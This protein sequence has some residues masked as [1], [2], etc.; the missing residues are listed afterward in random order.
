M[1]PDYTEDLLIEQPA[2]ELLRSLGW[3]E[4]KNLFHET[5]G[6]GGTEKRRSRREVILTHRLRK[7]LVRLNSLLPSEAIDLAVE[8]LTR[9]RSALIPV[10]A[11]EEYYRLLK[12]GVKVAVKDE[13]G[14]TN[15]ETVRVIDWNNAGNNDFFLASQFWVEGSLYTRRADLV[16]F[17]NGLPLLFIELK[18]SHRKLYNAYKDNL[19]DYK[20]AIPQLFVPNAVVILSNG[21][22][23]RLGSIT[24]GW[25]HFFDWKRISDEGEKGAVSL[26]IVL[27]GVCEPARFLDIVENFTVFEAV[28]GGTAKKISKNHQYLGVNRALESVIEAKENKGRLGVF[29]HTQGSGKS[30]SMVFFTQKILRKLAGNWTFLIVTDRDDLDTQIYK[31]FVATGA[32]TEEE[33]QA[34]SGE[35]LK[36]L[37]K[38]DHRYVFTLIQKFRAER[39]SLYPTLSERDDVIVI[40]DE[41]HRSQYDT[42]AMNMRNA[43]PNASFIGFTGT[44]LIRGEEEKTREVFGDY[45]SVYN[46]RRSIE[47]RAT[48]PLYYENRIP[49]LQ[50]KNEDL[51]RELERLLEDAELDEA[52]ERK[53]ERE[54]SRQ[55]HLITREER[56]DTIA[57]DV[58]EHFIGRGYQGKAM[59]IAVDKVT[60][61]KMYDK[62]K[63]YWQ[64]K[65]EE[66]TRQLAEE[67]LENRAELEAQLANLKSTDM[68]V[69]VSQSQNEIEDM[70][71]KGVEIE[72]HRR[73]I[74]SED[75]EEMF[76]D[77]AN[78]FRLAF[79]CAMWITGFDVPTCSTIYLDKP[80]R[81]HTLMQTIARAN[82]VA[83][84]K[85]AGLIV[86]YVGM[87]RDLQKALAIY[88]TEQG[89]GGQGALVDEPIKDKKALVGELQTI[90]SEL[91]EFCA[92]LGFRLEDIQTAEGFDKIRLLD[93]AVEILIARLEDKKHFL[94]ESQ[95]VNNLFRAIL[96]DTAASEIAP[97][98]TLIYVLRQKIQ[99]LNPSADIS[100]IMAGVEGILDESIAVE[101]YRIDA[102]V[103]AE[104]DVQ[105]LVDL[106]QIDFE[107]LKE[108][109]RV[110]S[111][112]HTELEKLKNQIEARLA[113]MLELNRTR[114]NFL[115]RF[116]KMIDEYN[117]GSRNLE[118]F[119]QELIDFA[120][121]L[122]EED[123]R[124]IAEGLTEEEL[125]IFDILTKPEPK[126]TKA[127]EIEVKRVAK[128][129]LEK[130]KG[131]KL[132]LD[133]RKRQQTRAEVLVTIEE[134][135]DLLP[136]VYTKPIYDK[137]CELA[138]EHFYV[139]YPSAGKSVYQEQ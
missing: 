127:E 109:F 24:A 38:E 92:R 93:D 50:L 14:A 75:L 88:A 28:R 40:T 32:V 84:G 106:S 134:I 63:K 112:K 60:A 70:R 12:D 27:R 34:T 100:D 59:F 119:F 116:Q 9:D 99:A 4:Y 135:L 132:V 57:R 11:N 37:L 3:S 101:G 77:P 79:V 120:Q 90:I 86:D 78:P 129:L 65:T 13:D 125:A 49:Q 111:R 113:R 110:T 42:L 29:W 102:P 25:E 138:Y 52:Q 139:Q 48:V 67:T 108:K 98:A 44:P 82:R 22:E 128:T 122:N 105:G 72:P 45:V 130:I 7:A 95:I 54:F 133:W 36:Q 87:F 96:P 83:E 58:V 107:A 41:A 64:I 35:N 85:V 5:F 26:E 97:N 126:L 137:K 30:L 6:D 23:T 66:I 18:T 53:L 89:D 124:K 46:F 39:G 81:N 80:M 17:I 51:D 62:V 56:L 91:K 10:N 20:T 16:G 21:T 104:G 19:R 74:V 76:K 2:I 31:T 121:N 43:L 94:V 117:A 1:T 33:A 115:E 136:P 8:E 103:R 15:Y 114:V 55:Y 131:E 69:I 68:A 123:Q 118:D 71:A 73:R 47:D 61:V